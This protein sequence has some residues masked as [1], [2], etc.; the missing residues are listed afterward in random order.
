MHTR[1]R[2]IAITA[3]INLTGV[4]GCADDDPQPEPPPGPAEPFRVMTYNVLC[5]FCD[6]E[7][8]DPWVERLEYFRDVFER[9]DP[10][11]IGLQELAFDSE[12]EQILGLLPS[13]GALYYRTEDLGHSYPDAT[14][15]YRAERFE[16]LSHGQ[17]WLS[18]TPDEPSSQGFSDQQAVPRLVQWAELRDRRSRRVL[19]FAT[20]HFD[21]NPPCQER[22]APLVLERTAPWSE[23]T[24][25]VVLGDFNSQ[26]DDEAYRV[27]TEGHDGDQ[28]L[29]DTQGRADQWQ[30]DSNQSPPPDYALD[31]RIDHIFVA[32][33]PER[34]SV[35]RWI[36]DLHVY[37]ALDRYPSD[38]WPIVADLTA[39]ELD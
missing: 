22:S 33:E 16:P 17:Y 25:A 9:H 14:I 28:P 23:Q 6:L 29:V 26:P 39:P 31:Q 8:H 7:H 13:Y 3:A 38:H 10:D 15:V 27:L 5:S 21:N 4:V 18:P 30:V 32:P 1:S 35:T 2:L 37:G 19:Y 34:W 11:L 24:P 12:V 20:T 36:A